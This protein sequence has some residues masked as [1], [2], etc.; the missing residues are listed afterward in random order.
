MRMMLMTACL[1]AVGLQTLPALAQQAA[2]PAKLRP[3][4]MAVPFYTP[5][6]FVQGLLRS[7]HAPLAAWLAQ[8][9]LVLANQVDA[10]CAASPA[11]AEAA[12]QAAREQWAQTM[13]AWTSLSTIA[14]GPLIERRSIRQLDFQ[15]ARPALID[16]A[17]DA[18]PANVQAL[19]TVG[20]PAR[21][22]PALEHLLWSQPAV[23]PATPACRYTAVLAQELVQETAALDAAF[24]AQ[25]RRAWTDEEEAAPAV[26]GEV[27]NQW[28]GSLEMLRWRDL[29]KP[30][31]SAPR[32]RQPEFPRT[33]S[34]KT[35]M[36]WA[37]QWQAIKIVSALGAAPVPPAGAG[38]LVPMETYLR[39]RGLNPAAD[40]LA[41]A[42]AQADVAMKNLSPRQSPARLQAAMAALGQLKLVVENEVA[43][44]L[45]ISIGFSDADG[46]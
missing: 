42:V 6:M 40:A 2:R 20:A 26:M 39:G 9:S 13:T 38:L 15:P 43:P 36:A 16:K 27:V 46:D 25:A 18:A 21:G 30:L 37:A 5:G 19:D 10:L 33:L 29:G 4:V 45:E 24:T 17:I 41:R 11:Q 1:L 22:L 23:A 3:Q 28:V 35:A 44:A 8:Q 12:R 31:A 34:Q 7:R 14:F 32:G